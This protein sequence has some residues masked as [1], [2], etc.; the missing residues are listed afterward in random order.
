M[1]NMNCW[2]TDIGTKE[3]QQDCLLLAIAGMGLLPLWITDM[4][5]DSLD[6]IMTKLASTF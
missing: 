6:P 5:R 2:K 4:I 1:L 3:F